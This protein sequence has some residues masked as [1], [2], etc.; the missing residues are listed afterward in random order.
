[1]SLVEVKGLPML[2]AK[3]IY[4][5]TIWVVLGLTT[6]LVGAFPKRTSLIWIYVTFSILVIYL[7]SL[8]EFPEWVNNI[9]AFHHI[10]QL[11]NEEIIWFPL[12]SLSLVGIVLS[13]IGFLSYNKRDIY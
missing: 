7:G 2:Q 11:P 5:P 12:S 4:G 3:P 13:V 1:M 6:V 9:S 10:P 8:L